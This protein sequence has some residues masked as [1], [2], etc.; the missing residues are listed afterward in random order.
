M[1][2]KLGS[3]IDG[4]T[5]GGAWLVGRSGL[6][7][8]TAAFKVA[9]TFHTIIRE[10]TALPFSV[11]CGNCP[12]NSTLRRLSSVAPTFL[13]DTGEQC[14]PANLLCYSSH[15]LVATQPREKAAAN[16]NVGP[17]FSPAMAPI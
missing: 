12:Q 16:S 10:S 13:K 11:K 3:T 2:E 14:L 1:Q 9:S 5:V 17:L 4:L 15:H 8:V 7:T 6:S